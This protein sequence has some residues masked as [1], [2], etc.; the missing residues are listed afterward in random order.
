MTRSTAPGPI[1]S[2]KSRTLVRTCVTLVCGA[3]FFGTEASAQK[4]AA[5]AAR[6]VSALNA[7][8]CRQLRAGV[9]AQ[10]AC[11]LARG[12]PDVPQGALVVPAGIVSDSRIEKPRA[13]AA[14]IAELVAGALGR[15]ARHSDEPSTLTSA[16]RVAA[17][18]AA[19]IF[20]RTEIARGELRVTA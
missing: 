4:H 6:D 16:R 7:N 15:A 11:M 17:G 8:D 3:S 2:Q 20:V 14:R 19:L 13:L 5:P 10:V 1:R 18:A 9:L 12:L